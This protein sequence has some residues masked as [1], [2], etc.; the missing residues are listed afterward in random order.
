MSYFDITRRGL[1][2]VLVAAASAGVAGCAPGDSGQSVSA[3]PSRRP[4]TTGSSR[5][6]VSA[7]P[8]A[9]PQSAITKIAVPPGAPKHAKGAKGVVYPNAPVASPSTPHPQQITAV[10][11]LAGLRAAVEFAGPIPSTDKYEDQG[12]AVEQDPSRDGLVVGVALC[13]RSGNG[14]ESSSL[15]A[16]IFRFSP[17][18]ALNRTTSV[19]VGEVLSASGIQKPEFRQVNLVEGVV[20]LGFAA[21]YWG[22]QALLA[23]DMDGNLLWNHAVDKP[24]FEG[25]TL[26][27][28]VNV[29]DA[30]WIGPNLIATG[31]PNRN[32]ALH[33]DSG[34]TVWENEVSTRYRGEQAWTTKDCVLLTY[35]GAQAFSVSGGTGFLDK[36]SSS[37]A[38]DPIA[39]LLVSGYGNLAVDAKVDGLVFVVQDAA[40]R[41]EVFS[42]ASDDP[43]A[44]KQVEVLAAYGGRA[45]VTT[46]EGQTVVDAKTGEKAQGVGDIPPGTRILHN[47]P[48]DWGANWVLI[49]DADSYNHRDKTFYASTTGFVPPSALPASAV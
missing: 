47:V 43:G 18:G 28:N 24:V 39:G 23:I 3:T 10:G 8:S 11:L 7:T 19:S 44:P 35:N 16:N 31:G 48:T 9:S 36:Y 1:L 37:A 4:S 46:P 2:T 22:P 13:S 30:L 21:P 32:L 33:L 6:S 17:A 42:M 41:S 40:T 45:W 12:W 14:L 38:L 27:A 29:H 25:E 34:E 5:S 49:G 26:G 20:L 15:V